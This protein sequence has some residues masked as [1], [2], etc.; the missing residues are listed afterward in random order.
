MYIFDAD[1]FYVKFHLLPETVA[2]RLTQKTEEDV[3]TFFHIKFDALGPWI[4]A[5]VM[6]QA[7]HTIAAVMSPMDMKFAPQLCHTHGMLCV[8]ISVPPTAKL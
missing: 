1:E 5:V 8:L 4:P 3:S 6:V 7:P 2:T